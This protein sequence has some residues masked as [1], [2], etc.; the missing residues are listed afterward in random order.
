MLRKTAA[1]TA[2]LLLFSSVHASAQYFN[3]NG[4][5]NNIEVS[6]GFQSDFRSGEGADLRLDITYGRFYRHGL[7]FRAGACYMLSN[8]GIDHAAGLPVAFAWRSK[9][10]GFEDQYK[11]AAVNALDTDTGAF[12]MEN[13]YYSDYNYDDALKNDLASRFLTFI[14]SLISRVELFTG[15]T[16]GYIFGEDHLHWTSMSGVN[17]GEPFQRGTVSPHA[18]F[19]SADA[20]LSLVI[21]IWRMSINVTPAVH[22]YIT[23]NYRLYNAA[24]KQDL[25]SPVRWQMSLSGGV[26]FM[27]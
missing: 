25:S 15:V 23:D 19:L 20:G 27:F 3:P 22:Y 16:P 6:A 5:R 4:F 12:D 21:R 9:V 26:N 2:L 24:L 17:L 13:Y 10:W 8:V 11:E 14:T 18:F 7:G 1:A